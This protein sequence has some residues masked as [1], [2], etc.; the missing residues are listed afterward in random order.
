[1]SYDNHVAVPRQALSALIGTLCVAMLALVFLL[2]RMSASGSSAAPASPAVA[3]A[4][5]PPLAAAEPSDNRRVLQTGPRPSDPLPTEPL[6]RPT[7]AVPVQ[8]PPESPPE[9][10]VSSPQVPTLPPPPTVP[11]GHALSHLVA[12]PPKPGAAPAGTPPREVKAVAADPGQ[13]AEVLAYLHQVDG[14]TSGTGDLGDP[15]DFANK[16]LGQASAGDTSAF[17][18]LIFKV[19]KAQNKLSG[20]TPPGP[21]KEHYHLVGEQ[22]HS[23]LALLEGL[24]KAI[25]SGDTSGLV[26][27]AAQGQAMQ[28]KLKQ[29]ETLTARLKTTYR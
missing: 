28:S 20:I 26:G 27:L 15:A 13:K 7:E 9:P 10:T 1:M 4:A 14:L 25:T 16:I 23:S 18:D 12:S 6:A 11:Q 3:V 19:H 17:D 8:A 5:A 24:K 29:L 22:L 21:C 2:G